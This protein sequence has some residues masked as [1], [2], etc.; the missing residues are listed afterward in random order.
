MAASLREWLSLTRFSGT[1]GAAARQ[2]QRLDP[3]KRYNLRPFVGFGRNEL[4]EVGR[5]H[6][7]WHRSEI[8]DPRLDRWMGKACVD[9]LIELVHY[10]GGGV[11]GR[12]DTSPTGRL[13]ARHEFAHGR[14]VR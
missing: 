12:A 4:G 2:S 7:H 10:F 6:R 13:V 9:F 14:D 11:S 1:Y 3:R 8:R 5:C